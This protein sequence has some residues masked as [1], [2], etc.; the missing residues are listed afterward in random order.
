M[1]EVEGVIKS[2]V[3]ILQ[4]LMDILA[5]GRFMRAGGSDIAAAVGYERAVKRG[6]DAALS[7]NAKMH[8]QWAN[9]AQILARIGRKR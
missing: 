7:N 8:R 4:A 6:G 3:G 9:D 1:S 5:W 2:G